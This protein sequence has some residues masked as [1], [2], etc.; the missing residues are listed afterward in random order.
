MK[1]LGQVKSAVTAE[2]NSLRSAQQQ[3]T[4]SLQ[5]ANANI[6]NLQQAQA[7]Q[8]D[9]AANKAKKRK[10]LNEGLLAAKSHLEQLLRNECQKEGIT[11]LD[12]DLAQM[13]PLQSLGLVTPHTASGAGYIKKMRKEDLPLFDG[14]NV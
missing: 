5:Q 7:A 6:N 10:I 11:L 2:M 14:T 12:E 1:E 3:A 13:A 8:I 4:A 9:P